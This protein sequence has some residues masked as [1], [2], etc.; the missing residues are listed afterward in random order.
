[1]ADDK[2]SAPAP[3][4]EQSAF[5]VEGTGTGQG[6]RASRPLVYSDDDRI[7][8]MY[9]ALAQASAHHQ[10]LVLTCRAELFGRLI[11]QAGGH[12]AAD[13]RWAAS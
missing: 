6:D 5:E 4:G 8:R 10:V 3:D 13:E 12:R 11:D 9:H 7:G 1:M 2:T